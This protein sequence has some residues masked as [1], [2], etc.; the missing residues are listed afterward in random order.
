MLAG[1][2]SKRAMAGSTRG[3][4]NSLAADILRIAVRLC[5]DMLGIDH[6][7][8]IL[9]AEY[10]AADALADAAEEKKLAGQ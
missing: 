3:P 1:T 4:M 7:K 9:D 8:A 6:T 10:A 2:W 5:V